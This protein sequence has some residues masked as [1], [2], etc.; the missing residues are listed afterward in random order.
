MKPLFRSYSR[1]MRQIAQDS[2]LTLVCCAG[3]LAALFFRFGVPAIERVLCVYFAQDSILADYYLL[4]DLLLSLLTPYMLLFASSMMMLTEFDENL[5]AYLAVTPVG[6]SGYLISRLGIPAVI[7][8]GASAL[9]LTTFA[10]TDWH[11]G[12]LILTC[13]IASLASVSVALLLFSFSHNRVEGMA[14]GK[15]SGLLMVGLF[16]PF[17]VS[18]GAQYLFSPFPSFWMAKLGETGNN[19]FAVPAFLS[20][21][22]WIALLYPRF[23][24]KLA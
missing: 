5:S 20:A 8:W 17:F 22:A 11:I 9:L 24:H 3:L 15:M 13:L 16:A 10:L 18:E 23:K 21:L 7:S 6:K 12:T 2:M 1:F 14:M 19:V 4:F